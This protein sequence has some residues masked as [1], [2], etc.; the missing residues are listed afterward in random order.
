MKTG[1]C[2]G[3]TIIGYMSQFFGRRQAI[4]LSALM[5][6]LMI[7]AWILPEGERGPS[8]SGHTVALFLAL[9]Y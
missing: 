6:G 4:I 1:A 2:I 3:G 9:L 5:S 8:A 7:P